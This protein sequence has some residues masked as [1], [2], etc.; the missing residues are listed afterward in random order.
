MFAHS[1]QICA[2]NFARRRRA[3]YF[4]A[5]FIRAAFVKTDD[6][7]VWR[8]VL[9]TVLGAIRSTAHPCRRKIKFRKYLKI[10][11]R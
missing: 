4:T 7:R 3:R 8:G 11:L 9:E 5:G 10:N 6:L 1:L 2:V